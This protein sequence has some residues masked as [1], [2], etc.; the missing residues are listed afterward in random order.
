MVAEHVSRASGSLVESMAT[1]WKVD[2]QKTLRLIMCSH[3]CFRS[4]VSLNRS[5]SPTLKVPVEAPYDHLKKPP[6][7]LDNFLPR[8]QLCARTCGRAPAAHPLPPPS[9]RKNHIFASIKQVMLT[10]AP[11]DNAASLQVLHSDSN[12]GDGSCSE[13]KAA[14]L[15]TADAARFARAVNKKAKVQHAE[16]AVPSAVVPASSDVTGA[17]FLTYHMLCKF[18]ESQV[19]TFLRRMKQLERV[20]RAREGLKK[21][22]DI[23]TFS[24]DEDV[25]CTVP[26]N[27]Q[28]SISGDKSTTWLH[29]DVRTILQ[30]GASSIFSEQQQQHAIRKSYSEPKLVPIPTLIKHLE[31]NLSV[32]A[33]NK[34]MGTD[35]FNNRRVQICRDCHARYS[36]YVLSSRIERIHE[37]VE[38]LKDVK[39]KLKLPL[40]NIGLKQ[41]SS[42]S[43]SA[44]SYGASKASAPP[45]LSQRTAAPAASS[46]DAR[47][48]NGQM[49][50]GVR[51]MLDELQIP[52]AAAS[53]ASS[54]SSSDGDSDIF[55]REDG[56]AL[57]PLHAALPSVHTLFQ[58]I[59]GSEW[60]SQNVHHPASQRSEFEDCKGTD[61]SV[62]FA[63]WM[64]FCKTFSV[65][66]RLP[67][68]KQDCIDCFKDANLGSLQLSIS[69][70]DFSNCLLQMAVKSGILSV[71]D[72]RPS[73][74]QR[75]VALSSDFS[76]KISSA[77]DLVKSERNGSALSSAL[78]TLFPSQEMTTSAPNTSRSAL[79][80]QRAK[81]VSPEVIGQTE[82]AIGAGVPPLPALPANSKG[83]FS[84]ET[85]SAIRDKLY[86]GKAHLR[87][88][89]FNSA[90]CCPPV[91]SGVMLLLR[92]LHVSILDT[93]LS[94]CGLSNMNV[95]ESPSLWQLQPIFCK[96]FHEASIASHNMI[97]NMGSRQKTLNLG[98]W[99]VWCA[100]HKV[101]DFLSMRKS[102]VISCFLM[103]G[104]NVTGCEVDLEGFCA[105]FIQ[106]AILAGYLSADQLI[107][108]MNPFVE[109][110]ANRINT[111]FGIDISS[112]RESHRFEVESRSANNALWEH[113]PVLQTWFKQAASEGGVS[114]G[115]R[116]NLVS[117]QEWQNFCR[118]VGFASLGLSRSD[119]TYAF[120]NGFSADASESSVRQDV[121]EARISEFCQSL[122]VIA[123]RARFVVVEPHS[124]VPNA[125]NCDEG[126]VESIRHM[127]SKLSVPVSGS[128]FSLVSTETITQLP[129][130]SVFPMHFKQLLVRT[131]DSRDQ[132]SLDQLKFSLPSTLLC[133]R[134][135]FLDISNQ[136]QSKS[137]PSNPGFGF[138]TTQFW[139]RF[140]LQT[141]ASELL[142]LKLVDA[143]TCVLA[144]DPEASQYRRSANMTLELFSQCLLH[145][146]QRSKFLLK[147]D[148]DALPRAMQCGGCAILAV[149]FMLIALKQAPEVLSQ[150][151][152]LKILSANSAAEH[153]PSSSI[154]SLTVV[155]P[156]SA[157]E[158]LD[159]LL[160]QKPQKLDWPAADRRELS[161]ALQKEEAST[162]PFFFICVCISQ[163]LQDHQERANMLAEI[164]WA[165]S[166]T[167]DRRGAMQSAN[168][169]PCGY[170]LETISSLC[171]VL[172][173]GSGCG[174]RG[175]KY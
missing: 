6:T 113:L 34:I 46:L 154:D 62:T 33:F 115:N 38:P 16:A 146:A 70:N 65:T 100:E 2:H 18:P 37:L 117:L 99:S 135:L 101:C 169:S 130:K 125:S 85:K 119:L 155:T 171:Q 143:V 167:G 133:L 128:T 93:P 57:R 161:V 120:V 66:E 21:S 132:C 19:S 5:C 44:R 124:V 164:G 168:T 52:L 106:M 111:Q 39:A 147:D 17:F 116:G 24:S 81:K 32:A 150:D 148:A 51:L 88:L 94:F 47:Y 138:E 139:I 67:I 8:C 95:Y 170:T 157:Q 79:P 41:K 42:S 136:I 123:V 92:R 50:R 54:G 12:D 4:G 103:A 112:L 15:Q 98:E 43:F 108:N 140:C 68:Q 27:Q 172:P 25:I 13:G 61:Q 166:M 142:H 77:I 11:Q 158:V 105:S 71:A 114:F 145:L 156:K 23:Q 173:F 45:M 160:I 90:V 1:Y 118:R 97:S 31:P 14:T 141:N 80:T 3:A 149:A 28:D 86:S 49:A 151:T 48:C 55:C 91:F 165:C 89:R 58:F 20:G 134:Q 26:E 144:A 131:F 159:K 73:K 110:D 104:G 76:F 36:T 64:N 59:A 122:I 127:L 129:K 78:A 7:A 74:P 22:I 82:G 53:H 107:D 75:A 35:E 153:Q 109:L 30:H 63:K 56:G 72:C 126:T 9:S 29:D 84:L 163:F 96:L 10:N 40:A 87:R 174:A 137:A 102:D 152:Y 162:C 60:C 175:R 69:V 121:Y 83:K